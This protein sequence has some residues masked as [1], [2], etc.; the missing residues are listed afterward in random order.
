[1]INGGLGLQLANGTKSA[2][3]AYGVIAATVW[4][5]YSAVAAYSERKRKR[6]SP[7]NYREIVPDSATWGMEMRTH[8]H[9]GRSSS[10]REP[11]GTEA[12][13]LSTGAQ[14]AGLQGRYLGGLP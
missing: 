3:I 14:K 13:S 4:L 11:M 7:S 6:N 2:K 12:R 1:M 10:L 8:G 5:A 9:Q